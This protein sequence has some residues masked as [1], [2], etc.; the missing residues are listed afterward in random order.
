MIRVYRLIEGAAHLLK[1]AEG[2]RLEP[3]SRGK[4]IGCVSL[5]MRA[6]AFEDETEAVSV[7]NEMKRKILLRESES[8]QRPGKIY[9]LVVFSGRMLHVRTAFILHA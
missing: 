8:S 1:H 6:S 9:N 4:E 5:C 3:C 7:N 2:F